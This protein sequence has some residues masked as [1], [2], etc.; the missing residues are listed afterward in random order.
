MGVDVIHTKLEIELKEVPGEKVCSVLDMLSFEGEHTFPQ[1]LARI[2]C[3]LIIWD[4][5]RVRNTGRVD[6]GCRKIE[7]HE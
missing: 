3:S 4:M 7:S 5:T 6:L 2:R 1:C